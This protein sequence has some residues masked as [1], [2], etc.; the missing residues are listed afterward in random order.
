MTL[1]IGSRI[2]LAG[3]H[4]RSGCCIVARSHFRR[5]RKVLFCVCKWEERK[6]EEGLLLLVDVAH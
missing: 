3:H 4:S 1:T 6:K 5:Q 2:I